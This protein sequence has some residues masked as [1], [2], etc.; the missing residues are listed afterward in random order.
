MH[1]ALAEAVQ[2]DGAGIVV[3]TD[4]A[5]LD[6]AV[7]ADAA[8]ALN[9]GDAV[10]A[11]AEDGGYVLL[12]LRRDLDVFSAMPWSTPGLLAATRTRLA[13]LGARA[14]ELPMQWDV[15]TAADWSRY[16]ALAAS[17]APAPARAATAPR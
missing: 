6:L 15:D 1:A 9:Q 17:S 10:L 2:A 13:A 11:P 16:R 5:S 14:T 4:C 3:G 12:G 8:A 7:L